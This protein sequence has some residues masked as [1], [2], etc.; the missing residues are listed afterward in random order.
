VDENIICARGR[1]GG[2]AMWARTTPAW[3]LK[4]GVV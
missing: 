2:I 3:E 1:G 4:S